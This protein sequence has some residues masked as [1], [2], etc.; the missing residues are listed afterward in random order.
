MSAAVDVDF[1]DEMSF[2]DTHVAE[3]FQ[4]SIKDI[5]T[6]IDT[7]SAQDQTDSVP[8]SCHLTPNV[9][10]I[11]IVCYLPSALASLVHGNVFK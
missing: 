6:N 5:H 2:E 1:A 3:D 11:C 7:M 4:H 9:R 8:V 10:N